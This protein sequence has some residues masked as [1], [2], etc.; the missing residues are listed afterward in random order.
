MKVYIFYTRGT[1]VKVDNHCSSRNRSV[2]VITVV[3]MVFCI[4]SILGALLDS[5]TMAVTTVTTATKVIHCL[6]SRLKGMEYVFFY[7]SKLG[8][9]NYAKNT[10]MEFNFNVDL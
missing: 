7:W 1:T 6:D 8:Q 9:Y 10:Y 5:K 4:L 2:V 3:A